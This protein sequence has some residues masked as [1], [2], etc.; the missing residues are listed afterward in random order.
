MHIK[1]SVIWQRECI[2]IYKKIF[3][4]DKEMNYMDFIVSKIPP[5]TTQV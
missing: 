4:I 1:L 3:N 2:Y 5:K